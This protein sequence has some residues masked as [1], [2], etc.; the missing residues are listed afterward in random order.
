MSVTKTERFN[1]RLDEYSKKKIEQAAAVTQCSV[2]NFIVATVLK[3]AEE[4]IAQHEEIILTD[5]DRDLFF[6][7]LLNPSPI[8]EALSNAFKQHSEQ[9]E[10][11]V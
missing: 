6:T 1:L 3:K 4:I 2:N 5:K 8:N 7:A 11:D 9:V 10:S